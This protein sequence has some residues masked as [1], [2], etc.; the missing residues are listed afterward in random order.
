MYQ[1]ISGKK[2]GGLTKRGRTPFLLSLPF[3]LFF[4]VF[5][6]LP[7]AGWIIGFFNYKPGL[8]LLDCEFV[9]LKY[10]MEIFKDW[11]QTSIVLRNTLV[12]SGLNLLFSWV[13]MI[14]AIMLNE[15]RSNK[16]RKFV[17]TATTLPNFVSWIIVY[18][19]AFAIFSNEGIVNNLLTKIGIL[20]TGVNVLGNEKIAWWFQTALSMW[21]NLG[22]SAIIYIAAVA[23]ISQEL[24]DAARVDGAGRL[25]EIRHIT[26]PG[27]LPTYFVLLLLSISNIL[28]NGFDQ[29]FAFSNPMVSSKLNV[30]DVYVYN[31]GIGQNLYAYSTVV[32]MSKSLISVLLLVGANW[33]SK[34]IRKE[35]IF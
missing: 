21:K 10:F 27:L 19:I 3:V 8:N 2:T 26:L 35:S 25:A 17:Q 14:F 15:I 11:R 5:S 28:S 4:I 1:K 7:L 12:L 13:P 6:Y 34:K 22:W 9:G 20:N 24:Y 31:L 16:V 29:Y 32:G 30:L 18:G 23:G 33:M